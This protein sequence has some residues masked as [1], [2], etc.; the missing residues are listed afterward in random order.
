MFLLNYANLLYQAAYEAPVAFRC[1]VKRAVLQ[2][3][4]NVLY[5]IAGELGLLVQVAFLKTLIV[6]TPKVSAS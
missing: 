3:A 4:E 6:D 2:A 1:S 5:L